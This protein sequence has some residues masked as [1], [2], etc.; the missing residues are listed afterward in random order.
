MYTIRHSA[1]LDCRPS[2]ETESDM[3]TAKQTYTQAD[4]ILTVISSN[5]QHGHLA[6]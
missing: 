6:V 4:R 3:Y 5:S 1:S 2:S